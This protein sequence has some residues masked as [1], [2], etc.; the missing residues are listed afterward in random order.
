MD[1]ELSAPARI[2]S[3]SGRLTTSRTLRLMTSRYASRNGSGSAGV[4]LMARYSWVDRSYAQRYRSRSN[5]TRVSSYTP[6]MAQV[7]A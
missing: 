7:Y 6:S 1:P 5:S 4:C 2:V 3:L